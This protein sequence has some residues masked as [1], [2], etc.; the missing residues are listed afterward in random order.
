MLH[1]HGWRKVMP[2][3]RHLKEASEEE[4]AVSKN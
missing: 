3:S 4:I 1:R 2:R